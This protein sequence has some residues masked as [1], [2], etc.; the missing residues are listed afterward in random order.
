MKLDIV[1][2]WVTAHS[3]SYVPLCRACPG[4]EGNGSNCKSFSGACS[5]SEQ[6]IRGSPTWAK[7]SQQLISEIHGQTRWRESGAGWSERAGSVLS[8]EKC[9]IVDDKDK[10]RKKGWKPTRWITW[11]AADLY[12]LWRVCK[13]PPGSETRACT[14]R[15]S[16]GT[17]EVRMWPCRK[18]EGI[19]GGKQ[20]ANK[21]E[22]SIRK[23]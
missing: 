23:S 13:S 3:G 7:F 16:S 6:S 10:S 20:E 21:P 1:T 12:A 5:G 18:W 9:I 11:K 22:T 15:G 14:Q 17:G 4:T 2:Q 19:R 8:P